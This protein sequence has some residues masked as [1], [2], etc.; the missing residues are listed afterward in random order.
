MKTGITWSLSLLLLLML[1]LLMACSPAE[2]G[3]LA[4]RANGE[5]F[6]RQGFV[7]KDGWEI[8]FDHVYVNLSD[9]TAYQTDPPYDA[10]SA[11][12]IESKTRAALPGVHLVDLAE[13]GADAE[14]LFIGAA[15]DAPAGQFNALSWRM[16][17]AADG[18]AAGSTLVMVGTA[19]AG[20]QT[21]PFTISI[22]TSYEYWCGDYVGDGRK[23]ILAANSTTDLEL[24]FHF[25]HIF[26]DAATPADDDL[27]LGAPGFA[28][29][30]AVASGGQLNATLSDLQAQ[31]DPAA[32]QALV[33]ILPS[34]GHVGEGHC[35]SQ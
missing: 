13:G 19:V 15:A 23:G 12:P 35:H 4:F 16:A 18:A 2:T 32:Y 33:D 14:P 5:D 20:S 3:E 6:V 29:F 17:P 26:G 7:S 10:H 34:L 28:P 8:T 1:S 30:A 11:A 31:M 27:N 22:P 9:I 24:T 21:I 25:D